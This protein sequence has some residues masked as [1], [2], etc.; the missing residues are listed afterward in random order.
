MLFTKKKNGWGKRNGWIYYDN[1]G[2]EKKFTANDALEV[3]QSRELAQCD[4][5][6]RPSEDDGD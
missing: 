5:E 2:K 4:G 6:E 1:F 3:T